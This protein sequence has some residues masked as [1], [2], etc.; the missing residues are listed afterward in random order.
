VLLTVLVS[1]ELEG[2]R[3]ESSVAEYKTAPWNI[4]E[5]TEECHE[6]PQPGCPYVPMTNKCHLPH[7]ERCGSMADI[8]HSQRCGPS[9]S[10]RPGRLILLRPFAF[11]TSTLRGSCIKWFADQ[12]CTDFPKSRSHRKILGSRRM[13]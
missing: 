4:P 12:G 11:F 9:C 5:G 13:I 10:V 2:M 7:T 6:R 1:N 8:L 3:K